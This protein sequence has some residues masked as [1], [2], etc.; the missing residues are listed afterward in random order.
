MLYKGLCR[1]FLVDYEYHL[2][3]LSKLPIISDK[4]VI[5]CVRVKIVIVLARRAP[6]RAF[7]TITLVAGFARESSVLGANDSDGLLMVN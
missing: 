1:C 4:G 6:V 7:F 3:T 5:Y 2:D